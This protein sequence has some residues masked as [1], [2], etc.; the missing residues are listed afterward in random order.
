MVRVLK[1]EVVCVSS[2]NPVCLGA[3]GRI[4]SE[5]QGRFGFQLRIDG[6]EGLSHRWIVNIDGGFK[7]E[8]RDG[9]TVVT[10]VVSK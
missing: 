2:S 6:Y 4:E 5:G 8:D 3:K 9:T 10:P 7:V 1:N